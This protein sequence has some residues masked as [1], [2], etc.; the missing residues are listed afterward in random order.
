MHLKHELILFIQVT[1]RRV[2]VNGD[3]PSEKSLLALDFE[4]ATF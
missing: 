4:S 3:L 1:R 2:D